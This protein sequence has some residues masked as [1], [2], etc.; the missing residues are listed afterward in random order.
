MVL[1]V[2]DNVILNAHAQIEDTS[3]DSKNIVCEELEQVFG[4]FPKY[5]KKV[6]LKRFQFKN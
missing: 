2:T 1:R 3:D 4:H 6:L 5:Q